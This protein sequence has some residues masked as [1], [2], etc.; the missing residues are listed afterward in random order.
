MC[1]SDLVTGTLNVDLEQACIVSLEPVPALLNVDFTLVYLPEDIAGRRA[2][3]IAVD[4]L[5]EEPPDPLPL[6]GIDLGE[7][8]AEQLA[9][10]LDPYPRAEG[11]ELAAGESQG[12][13]DEGSEKKPN[14]FEIL[15][16][17]KTSE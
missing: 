5:A 4:P 7:A 10:A 12:S 11:A 17:L 15:K 13:A 14:P 9:L 16:N 3:E 2:L 1:S 8:V 6:E